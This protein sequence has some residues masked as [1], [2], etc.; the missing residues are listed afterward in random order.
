MSEAPYW[1]PRSAR[2]STH[3]DNPTAAEQM[4]ERR[5][6]HPELRGDEVQVS[7]Q[8]SPEAQPAK[9]PQFAASVAMSTAVELAPNVHINVVA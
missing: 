8:G 1:A 4:W 6:G 2:R 7:S 9:A 3:F 5:Y